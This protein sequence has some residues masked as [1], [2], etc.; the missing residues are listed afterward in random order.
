MGTAVPVEISGPKKILV[1]GAA[2]FL[3]SHLCDLLLQGGARVWGIDN[4]QSGDIANLAGALAQPGFEF[5]EHDV[6][7]PLTGD[8]EQIYHLA[9]PASPLLYQRDPVN[10]AKVNAIGTLNMLELART[11]GARLLLASSSEIYGEPACHPQREDCPG[12]LD[13]SGPRACYSESKRLGETLAADFHRAH[14]LEVRVARIFNTYGARMRPGDGR[15]M[16][17]FISQA[18]A[19]ADL[20]IY[21]RGTQSRSFCHYRDLL[22]ALVALMQLEGHC[23]PVNLGNPHE[24]EIIELARRIIALTGSASSITFQ[25]LPADDPRRRCPDI[26]LAQRLLDWRPNVSLEQGLA[27]MIRH[28]RAP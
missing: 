18:L 10:T 2:G 6:L 20:T 22:R 7:V 16:P 3:G 21:G 9:S 14:G 15:V 11:C 5:R 25:A 12:A 13:P 23:G 4:F 28:F 19:G 17:N 8:F 26:G 1:T 27:E 24:I